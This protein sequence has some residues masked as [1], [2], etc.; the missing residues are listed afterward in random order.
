[1]DTEDRCVRT[2]GSWALIDVGLWFTVVAM[3][4]ERVAEDGKSILRMVAAPWMI[5]MDDD[6]MAIFMICVAEWCILT[7]WHTPLHAG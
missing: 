4:E 5:L 6:S 7:H 1:M 2:H 3:V